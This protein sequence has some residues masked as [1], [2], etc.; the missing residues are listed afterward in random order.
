M[1]ILLWIG[2]LTTVVGALAIGAGALLRRRSALY[3]P[4]ADLADHFERYA[5]AHVY[6]RCTRCGAAQHPACRMPICQA[7]ARQLRAHIGP[8]RSAPLATAEGER[9]IRQALGE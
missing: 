5:A 1:H 8:R 2:A 9:L 3:P 7:C 4:P 6:P